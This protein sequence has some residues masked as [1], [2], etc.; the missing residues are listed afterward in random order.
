MHAPHE[1]LHKRGDVAA[2]NG[3]GLYGGADDIA[4]RDGDHMRAA[5]P[6]V[7]HCAGQRA[8][9]RLHAQASG[10]VSSTLLLKL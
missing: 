5:V 1:L 4:V 8:R 10:V 7:D 6:A 9:Q 2:G 3:D